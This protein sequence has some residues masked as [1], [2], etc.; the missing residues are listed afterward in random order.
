[1]VVDNG[2]SLCPQRSLTDTLLVEWVTYGSE[3]GLWLEVDC[4]L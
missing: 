2:L 1:M 3:G 4:C